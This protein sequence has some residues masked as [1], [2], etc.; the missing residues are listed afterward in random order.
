MSWVDLHC[1]YLPDVDDGVRSLQ[2]GQ[3]LCRKLKELGFAQVFA[4][5]HV[6]PRAYKDNCRS[7]L[8]SRFQSFVQQCAG[9][10]EFPQLGLGGEHFLDENFWELWERKEIIPYGGSDALLIEFDYNQIPLGFESQMFK[11][12]LQGFTPLVAHP[13]RYREAFR[14][15]RVLQRLVEMQVPLALDLMSLAGKYGKAPQ[16]AAERMLDEDLYFVACSD[17]H[18]PSDVDSVS[19]GLERLKRRV[20]QA[21]SAQLLTQNPRLLLAG[22]AAGPV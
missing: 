9:Q 22:A 19:Q 6:H 14:S 12:Q 17:A 11:L 13:E 21:R 4:T 7:Y 20:G 16:R 18:R 3:R 8:T 10:S 1:H 2:D 15:S 5:P